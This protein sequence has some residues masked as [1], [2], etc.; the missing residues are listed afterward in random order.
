M[1]MYS[2]FTPPLLYPRGKAP[3][4]HRTERFKEGNNHFTTLN[5]TTIESFS[6]SLNTK[7]YPSFGF[8]FDPSTKFY[9][10]SL[11]TFKKRLRTY[12]TSHLYI[13]FIKAYPA[14]SKD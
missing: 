4:T 2:I 11:R 1:E 6:S 7:L 8:K 13:N 5:R 9:L 10:K 3:C 12:S 14:L